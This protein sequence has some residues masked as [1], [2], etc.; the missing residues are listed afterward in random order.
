MNV[1]SVLQRPILWIAALCAVAGLGIL[2]WGPTLRAQRVTAAPISASEPIDFAFTEPESSA[3][4]EAEAATQPEL[5]AE[6]V[7]YI[8]GAVAYPDVYR[9]PADARVKDAVLAAGGLAPDA[10]RDS[11]NLAA[12]LADEQHIHIS[13]A[14]EAATVV[15][16]A[17]P[18]SASDGR[19]DLNAATAA[20]LE[21]LPGVGPTLAQRII[22]QRQTQGKFAS[23]DDL[24]AVSG[25]GE[26]LFAQIA[27]FVWV[28]N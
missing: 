20:E 22:A 6:V 13:R 26:K 21:E 28:G 3:P 12:P 2:L 25:I 27:P 19:L 17:P 8:S 16:A 11:I 18:E 7:I 23:V 15:S 10:A 5:P 24:R 1:Q 4:V 9:L 14:S